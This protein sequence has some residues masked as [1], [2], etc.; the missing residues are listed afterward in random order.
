MAILFA[1]DHILRDVDQTAGQVAG[2]VSYT[3]LDVYKRQPILCMVGVLVLIHHHIA[4]AVL[5]AGAHLLVCLLYT[6]RCV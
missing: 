1:D 4:K 2:A 5:I 6:S 3:H